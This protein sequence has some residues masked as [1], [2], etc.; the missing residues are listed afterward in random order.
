MK[1]RQLLATGL[2]MAALPT[3]G[4]AQEAGE[5]K[6]SAQIHYLEIVTPEVEE[7]C[8]LYTRLHGLTFGEPDEAL[9]GARTTELEA[10]GKLGI[11]APLRPTEAPIVRPYTL[12]EDI[13]TSVDAAAA[14]GATVALPPTRLGDHGQCAILILGGIEAGVWQ[15]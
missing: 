11:R 3:M 6:P 9:G 8:A 5:H 13:Q 4:W 15:I 1:R 12:V 7:L 10:G 2:A 14:A